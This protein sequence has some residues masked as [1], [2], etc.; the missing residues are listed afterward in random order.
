MNCI[1]NPVRIVETGP[2]RIMSGHP[3]VKR[4]SLSG[5]PGSSAVINADRHEV[6]QHGKPHL[7]QLLKSCIV[8]THLTS[9]QYLHMRNERVAEVPGAAKRALVARQPAALCC[10]KLARLG[11]VSVSLILRDRQSEAEGVNE[12][13]KIK[14]TVT[15]DAAYTGAVRADAGSLRLDKGVDFINQLPDTFS[16]AA[17]RIEFRCS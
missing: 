15:I 8:L 5:G 12:I 9:R 1:R 14:R 2:L 16:G 3:V 7:L 10:E 11:L 17:C 13:V 6:L 4:Q